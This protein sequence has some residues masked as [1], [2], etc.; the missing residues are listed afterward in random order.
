MRF[1]DYSTI[2]CD[3][4]LSSEGNEWSYSHAIIP[5]RYISAIW[6][7]FLYRKLLIKSK[8]KKMKLSSVI[9]ATVAAHGRI[10]EPPGRSSL[11]LFP[12]DPDVKVSLV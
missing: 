7:H 2:E 1:Y 10:M 6:S 4:I 5:T 12:D 3:V 8:N 11:R 9:I